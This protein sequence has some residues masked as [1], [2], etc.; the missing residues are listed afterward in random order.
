[1]TEKLLTRREVSTLLHCSVGTVR[2]LERKG[3][4][5]PIRISDHMVRFVREEI[6]RLLA[7]AGMKA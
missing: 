5:R 7:D 1:M 4:L 2:R 6:E 3:T